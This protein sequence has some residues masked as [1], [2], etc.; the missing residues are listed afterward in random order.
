MI[1]TIFVYNSN[2]G[3][4]LYD[5]HFQKLDSGKIELFSSFFSAV[6]AV[7]SEIVMNGAKE[8]KNIDLGDYSVTITTI[9]DLTVDLVIIADKEDTKT[10]NKLTPKVIKLLKKYDELFL[11]N[12]PDLIVKNTLNDELYHLVFSSVNESKKSM[13]ENPEQVLKSLWAQR[14]QITEERRTQLIQDRDMIIYQI[15]NSVLLPYKIQMSEKV[16]EISEELHDETT[17]LNYQQDINRLRNE[18]NDAKFKL[19]YYISKVKESLNEAIKNLADKPLRSGDYKNTYLNL[20]S[21][22]S[23]LKLFKENEWE[24]YRELANKLI[25]KESISEHELSDVIQTILRM[26]TN[27]QD[28]LN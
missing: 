11:S 12:Y 9:P 8:L 18:L 24:L 20:Y 22:S 10:I 6:K 16:L 3:K 19:E 15:E 17:F 21:F 14:S 27:A 28:Y 25:D 5:Q 7:I 4:L 13:L 1:Y 26:S 23:K 2:N